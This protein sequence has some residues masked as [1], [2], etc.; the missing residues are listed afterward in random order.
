MDLAGFRDWLLN[1]AR[2]GAH[3][4]AGRG[5]PELFPAPPSPP[6]FVSELT[7]LLK[8]TEADRAP[9]PAAGASADDGGSG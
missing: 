5:R 8:E 2:Q 3:R 9:G 4:R 6:D 7:R 1:R